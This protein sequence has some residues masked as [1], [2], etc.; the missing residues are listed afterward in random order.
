MQISQHLRGTHTEISTQHNP[1]TCT[2]HNLKTAPNKYKKQHI[3]QATNK[4]TRIYIYI[5]ICIRTLETTRSLSRALCFFQGSPWDSGFRIL[6]CG[7]GPT[8][9]GFELAV[10]V[11]IISVVFILLRQG[12]RCFHKTVSPTHPQALPGD[13]LGTPR[14]PPQTPVIGTYT[15]VYVYGC[16]FSDV[17]E[18]YIYIY[19]YMWAWGGGQTSAFRT[20][21]TLFGPP[22]KP[23]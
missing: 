20:V 11:F 13:P 15:H 4:R 1:T 23:L 16:E 6:N 10:T 12:K 2:C 8:N 7:S 14:G 3:T 21:M 9:T 17:Q 19:I 5:Y 18:I 22:L